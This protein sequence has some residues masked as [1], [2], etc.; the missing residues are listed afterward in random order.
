M[1]F[2]ARRI[3]ATLD[4][5]AAV[6]EL[7]ADLFAEGVDA[8]VKSETRETV[9]AVK[10][11]RKHEVSNTEIAKFLKLDTGTASRRVREAV[12]RGYLVNNETRKGRPSCI[13]LGDPMPSDC[14]ILPLP[15]ELAEC[16]TVA[17]LAGGY[18]TPSLNSFQ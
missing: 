13:A 14:Q 3:F 9:A 5:Y 4:D 18:A 15:K 6:R 2:R 11:L 7:V 12:S 1:A 10:A 8:T 16:C 17:A